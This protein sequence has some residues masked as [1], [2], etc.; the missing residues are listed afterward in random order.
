MSYDF[1]KYA[2]I[3]AVV[4][5]FLIKIE[6]PCFKITKSIFVKRPITT[7]IPNQQLSIT[8]SVTWIKHDFSISS[9]RHL[10]AIDNKAQ[11]LIYVKNKKTDS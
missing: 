9:R 6:N 4:T 1:K 11:T 3:S 5:S 2:E 10:L 8:P 7:A